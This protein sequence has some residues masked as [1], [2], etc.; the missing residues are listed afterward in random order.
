MQLARTSGADFSAFYHWHFKV[1][2]YNGDDTLK[3][4]I[5]HRIYFQE[6][7]GSSHYHIN[8]RHY[9]KAEADNNWKKWNSSF[10]KFGRFPRKKKLKVYAIMKYYSVVFI[11]SLALLC[12]QTG[13]PN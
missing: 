7:L 4:A 6:Q 11:A 3:G 10:H 5:H 12:C 13:K 1:E 2:H 8:C 9:K